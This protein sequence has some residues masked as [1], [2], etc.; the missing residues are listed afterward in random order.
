ML[1][2]HLKHGRKKLAFAIVLLAAVVAAA[3]FWQR[4]IDFADRPMVQ[5]ATP[6]V[7]LVARGDGLGAV[8]RKLRALGVHGGSSLEW[9]ALAARM[10]VAGKLQV[11]EYAVTPG[12]SPRALLD[13]L[14]RGE[15]IQRKYTL[16]EGWSFR[17]VRRALAADPL[18]VHPTTQPD[19]AALMRALGRAGQHP[20]GRFLPE[21]YVYT[22]GTDEVAVLDRAAKAMDKALAE[23]WDGRAAGLPYKSPDE[24]LTMA[25]IVE[26][27]TGLAS[28]RPLIA[29][30]FVR[31]LGIGMRLQTDPTVIYG[32]GAAYAGNIRKNDLLTDTP[33]NT[34]VRAGLPPTPIAMPGLAALQ[35]AA[36]PA[37]GDA[38]YFVA[39]GNG[40]HE[41]S[42]NL[43]AHEAAVRRYQL[44]R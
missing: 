44:R 9:K 30:V 23:A 11:G 28:E 42:S 10:G 12:L 7:L 17:D 21:T 40:A 36:H 26:K 14:A 41:F 1:A 25:S 15:V 16:I 34:Y 33:Y 5:D 19:D 39:R 43:A 18:L 24:L 8:V 29:G 4:T 13:R 22:R 32:M 20:E 38:L 6:R 31:R 27:E 35:A 3:L 37:D 2:K